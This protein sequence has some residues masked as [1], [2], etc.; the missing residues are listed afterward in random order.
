MVKE[1]ERPR[2]RPVGDVA[3]EVERADQGQTRRAWQ[4]YLDAELGLRNYWYPAF[5]TPELREGET[6]SEM[7]CGERIYFKRANGKVYAIEDRCP[8]RGVNF[9]ARPECYT[10][11]TVTCW[12][13]GFTFDVRDGRL[14]SVLS[15]NDSPLVGKL[16]IKTYPTYE[17]NQVVFVYIGDGEPVPPEEDML[18]TFKRSNLVAKPLVRVK[19]RCNWRMACE[20]G[21]D[22]GHLYGHR[23]WAFARRYNAAIPLGT[24]SVTKDDIRWLEEP[25]QPRGILVQNRY[26]NWVGT[27][28]DE[29]EVVHV[30]SPLVDPKGPPPTFAYPE[31]F[32]CFLPCGLDVAGFPRPDLYHWEWYVPV[33]EHHHM[34]TIVQGA[35][36]ETAEQ[37]EH[38][39]REYEEYLATDIWTPPEVQPEGFN[40][41]DALGR[42]AIHQAYAQEDWWHR[43]RMYKPDYAII[44]WRM[45]VSKYAR[46]IQKRGN[47]QPLLP[48]EPYQLK[49]YGPTGGTPP[50][51]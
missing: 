35:D 39:Y 30:H 28:E 51:R 24:S 44:Q 36:G 21:F 7:I 12:L 3:Q 5:F 45:M 13:H 23:V 37:R 33:D 6:R 50:V 46:G 26:A 32:G 1:R 27:I 11:N 18:P 16:D 40:N 9:S 49:Y 34:Y 38:F 8:H 14:V 43:E 48:E 17:R 22:P 10:K 15:E 31:T 4:R 42:A 2:T 47:W 41:F 20:N 25:G 19:I 29:D